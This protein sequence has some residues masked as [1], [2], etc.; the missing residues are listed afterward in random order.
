MGLSHRNAG[1]ARSTSANESTRT[2]AGIDASSDTR[3]EP[4]PRLQKKSSF[5]EWV[6]QKRSFTDLFESEAFAHLSKQW[7]SFKGK[8]GEQLGFRT[9]DEREGAQSPASA[10]RGRAAMESVVVKQEVSMWTHFYDSYIY[11]LRL[12][13]PLFTCYCMLAPFLVAM[14]FTLVYCFDLQGEL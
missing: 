1:D 7:G 3:P 13:A 11:L 4:R 12:P 9:A 14:P 10:L 8:A 2:T 6:Q 5:R